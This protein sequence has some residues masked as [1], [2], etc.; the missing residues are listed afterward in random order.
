MRDYL[1]QISV[2]LPELPNL[3]YLPNQ[4]FLHNYMKQL[5]QIV[6]NQLYLHRLSEHLSDERM[7]WQNHLIYSV[8]YKDKW[9]NLILKYHIFP[10]IHNKLEILEILIPRNQHLFS[11]GIPKPCF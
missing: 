1:L 10:N 9:K 8:E 5:Y 2:N 11:C 3:L 7:F 6:S 4:F